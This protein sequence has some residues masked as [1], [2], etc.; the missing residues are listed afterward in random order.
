[1]SR[2]DLDLLPERL[3]SQS[4]SRDE[5]VLP[6]AEALEA[7][8]HLRASGVGLLGWEGWVSRPNGQVGHASFQGTMDIVQ[9]QGESWDEYVNRSADFCVKTIMQDQESWNRSPDD[10]AATLCFCITLDTSRCR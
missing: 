6:Y 1:M 4:R 2:N 7:I 10:P 5:I 3:K 9:S 8:A